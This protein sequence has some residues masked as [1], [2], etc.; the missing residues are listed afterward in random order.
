MMKWDTGMGAGKMGD[1]RNGLFKKNINH[2]IK[3][4]LVT[5]E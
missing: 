2:K 4:N 5:S 3:D 1:D